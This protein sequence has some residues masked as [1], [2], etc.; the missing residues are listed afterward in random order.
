MEWWHNYFL[1][2]FFNLKPWHEYTLI[3]LL[4]LVT[5]MMWWW[6]RTCRQQHL[7][8]RNT[9][10]IIRPGIC[11]WHIMSS[12][13][14]ELWSNTQLK[15]PYRSSPLKNLVIS[16]LNAFNSI[17]CLSMYTL[18]CYLASCSTLPL[19]QC[20]CEL[21]RHVDWGESGGFTRQT[22]SSTIHKMSLLLLLLLL[23]TA[24]R[25]ASLSLHSYPDQF[26]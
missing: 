18:H 16:Y 3:L 14:M 6:W 24:P 9:A 21:I 12:T 26:P 11:K 7:T 25:T 15:Y 19:F 4:D 8:L 17:T 13:L 22:S 2:Y 5:M 20:L 1:K 10:K 23:G